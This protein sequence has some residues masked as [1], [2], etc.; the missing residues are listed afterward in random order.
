MAARRQRRGHANRFPRVFLAS[1]LKWRPGPREPLSWLVLVF[2]FSSSVSADFLEARRL[3]GVAREGP[4]L[5]SGTLFSD[6]GSLRRMLP[7]P[8][9]GFGSRRWGLGFRRFSQQGR[10]TNKEE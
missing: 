7:G 2:C 9:P 6:R 3:Q 1:G 5:D 4:V 8:G 10:K